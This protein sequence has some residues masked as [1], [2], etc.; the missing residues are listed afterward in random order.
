MVSRVVKERADLRELIGR[1]ACFLVLAC[2]A[3]LQ[4]SNVLARDRKAAGVQAAPKL[5]K[6]EQLRGTWKGRH[7]AMSRKAWQANRKA[8]RS[9]DDIERS[10][11]AN[12]AL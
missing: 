6:E 5:S 10:E 2:V 3:R 7:L 8:G 12:A 9:R 11:K 4:V 1:E